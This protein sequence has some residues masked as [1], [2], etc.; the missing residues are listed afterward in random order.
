MKS[1]ILHRD[2]LAQMG[3]DHFASLDHQTLIKVACRLHET[4]VELWERVHQNSQNTS[5]PPS[6]DDPF[7]KAKRQKGTETSEG[8]IDIPSGKDRGSDLRSKET[9]PD[10]RPHAGVSWSL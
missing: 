9:G 5:R 3:P 10:Q 2:D 8:D 4:A 7:V 1:G 6:S